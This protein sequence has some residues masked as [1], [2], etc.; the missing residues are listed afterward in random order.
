[1]STIE[2][3]YKTDLNYPDNH[4]HVITYQEPSQLSLR[5]LH[6]EQS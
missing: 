3:L 6:Y 2:E 5:K 1:M 4:N